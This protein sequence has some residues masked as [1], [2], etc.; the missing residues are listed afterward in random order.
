MPSPAGSPRYTSP[1]VHRLTHHVSSFVFPQCKIA[2]V[3]NLLPLLNEMRSLDEE[4]ATCSLF[5]INS[6]RPKIGCP[7]AAN[8]QTPCKIKGVKETLLEEAQTALHHPT[9]ESEAFADEPL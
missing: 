3:V 7:A 9:T 8:S 2:P 4:L 6:A 1:E 5:V